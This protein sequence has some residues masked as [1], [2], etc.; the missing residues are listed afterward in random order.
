M[1]EED[2]MGGKKETLTKNGFKVSWKKE[3]MLLNVPTDST[4][5]TKKR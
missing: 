1:F 3:T 5:E 2:L 4:K